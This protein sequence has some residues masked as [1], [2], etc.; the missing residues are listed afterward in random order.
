MN[1]RTP[2]LAA[3]MLFLCPAFLSGAV[4]RSD[5]PQ[6]QF[7]RESWMKLNGPWEFEFDD[8]DVGAK[9]NW[10]AGTHKFSKS[11]AVPYCFESSLSGIGDRA[12]HLHAILSR[13]VQRAYHG[14][15]CLLSR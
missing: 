14:H 2:P 9:E 6:P 3:L 1:I 7:Q 5:Y 15:F 4:A 12:F 10:P 11:I 13:E 8:A